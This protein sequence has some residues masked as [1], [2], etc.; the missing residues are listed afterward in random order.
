M[1]KKKVRFRP[2]FRPSEIHI[3]SDQNLPAMTN[4]ICDKI[5]QDNYEADVIVFR[6]LERLKAKELV[7]LNSVTYTHYQHGIWETD[8]G[9]DT[10]TKCSQGPKCNEG[11]TD[12]IILGPNYIVLIEIK[13]LEED[14][15]YLK[16]L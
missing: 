7:V 15:T 12:F 13:N 2:C 3:Y 1:D 8:H 10:C 5:H 9:A 4:Q 6:A 16:Q 14:V 11:E